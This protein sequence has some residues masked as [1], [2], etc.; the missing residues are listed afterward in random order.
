MFIWVDCSTAYGLFAASFPGTAQAGVHEFA[1]LCV[2]LRDD[3]DADLTGIGLVT[4]GQVSGGRGIESPQ[5]SYR[6][7]GICAQ[8]RHYCEVG[9]K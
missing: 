2:S 5:P 9:F 3:N 8:R 4:C 6:Q 1:A 7:S